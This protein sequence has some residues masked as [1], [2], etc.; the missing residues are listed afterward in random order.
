MRALLLFALAAAL[1]LSAATVTLS[2]GAS[3]TAST[4]V[5]TC[6][7]APLP[8]I[9]QPNPPVAPPATGPIPPPPFAVDHDFGTGG[10]EVW[11]RDG[12]VLQAGQR[13]TIA[14][15]VLP[16]SPEAP[17][18]NPNLDVFPSLGTWI[19]R[20]ITDYFPNVSDA[21]TRTLPI[22]TVADGRGSGH[23]AGVPGRCYQPGVCY[24]TFSLDKDQA[25]RM[26]YRP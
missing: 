9:E 12:R 3:C 7:G 14:F 5:V 22:G 11:P 2:N 4:V 18:P 1:D 25:V 23:D 26:Q 20:K 17:N 19:A 13:F 10:G 24:Y 6:T 15:T 16:P 8:P 21:E